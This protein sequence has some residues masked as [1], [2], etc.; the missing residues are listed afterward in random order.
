MTREYAFSKNIT[1]EQAQAIL[2]EGEALERA[3]K[4]V[5]TEDGSKLVVT[6]EGSEDFEVVMERLVNIVSRLTGG[7]A[8]SFIRFVF[9][10]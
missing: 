4:I 10:G 3:Q 9:E 1:E 5:V 6:C 2:S 8:F 7:I